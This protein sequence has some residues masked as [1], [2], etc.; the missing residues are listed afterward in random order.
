MKRKTMW[1]IMTAFALA[2][3][4]APGAIF[5]AEWSNVTLVDSHCAQKANVK[6]NP[7]SHTRDCML[8]CEKNGYGIYTSEGEYLKFD[9]EGSKKAYDLLK[10]SDKV[11]HLRVNVTGEREGDTLK[12]STIA[13]TS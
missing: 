6:E 3:L 13:M 4:L 5:A 10:A 9:A 2:A 1:T 12:V 8:M 7:D 11:D